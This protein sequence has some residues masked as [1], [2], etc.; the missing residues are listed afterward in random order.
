MKVNKW[1]H[2]S[3]LGELSIRHSWKLIFLSVLLTIALQANILFFLTLSWHH[4][5]FVSLSLLCSLYLRVLS[6]SLCLHVSYFSFLPTA[7]WCERVVKY[8]RRPDPCV[9]GSECASHCFLSCQFRKNFMV[10]FTHRLWCHLPSAVIVSF[11]KKKKKPSNKITGC[12][13]HIS[14]S[15]FVFT[16]HFELFLVQMLKLKP[17]SLCLYVSQT[18]EQW[19]KPTVPFRMQWSG[20]S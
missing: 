15:F 19:W 11:N 18:L 6:I 20:A 12:F 14:V 13:N 17:F 10:Y 7:V 3:F 5:R 9:D 2:F 1:Q 8:L 16:S 4:S